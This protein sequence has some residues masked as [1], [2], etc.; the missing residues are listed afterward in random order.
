MINPPTS[1]EALDLDAARALRGLGWDE[2][3][4]E[5]RSVT[6]VDIWQRTSSAMAGLACSTAPSGFTFPPPAE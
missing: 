1:S 6:S 3:L 2:D 4:D 5:M